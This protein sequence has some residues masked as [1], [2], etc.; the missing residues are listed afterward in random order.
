M[1]HDCRGGSNRPWWKLSWPAVVAGLVM[2]GALLVKNLDGTVWS[3]ITPMLSETPWTSYI[4]DTYRMP[5]TIPA[6]ATRTTHHGWP[7]KCVEHNEW[8]ALRFVLIRSPWWIVFDLA[9]WILLIVGTISCVK[10]WSHNGTIR[11]RCSLRG[12]FAVTTGF[13]IQLAVL[14]HSDDWLWTVKPIATGILFIGIFLTCFALID[15]IGGLWSLVVHRFAR[16]Q[17]S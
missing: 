2:L 7:I 17:P 1:E 10:R 11:F 9:A 14:L 6:D 3:P 8:P 13:A 5:V 4:P 15:W 16:S 12:M